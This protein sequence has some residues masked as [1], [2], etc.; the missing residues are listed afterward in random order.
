MNTYAAKAERRKLLKTSALVLALSVI[1][2]AAW[3]VACGGGPGRTNTLPAAAAAA[4][5]A[6]GSL[7]FGN[8]TINTTSAAQTVTL[9][10][11]GNA[12]LSIAGISVTGT[13]AGDFVQ[14]NACGSSL[15]AGA[16]C[17]IGVTF[18]P[19]ATGTRAGTLTITDNSGTAGSTQTV[20]L[21]GTGTSVPA[22][23][24]S[25]SPLSLAF[26]NETVYTT[27]TAQ[28]LTLSN[29]GNT[30][31]SITSLALTGSNA[32]DFDQSNT[33]GSSLAAGANCTIAVMFTPSVTGTRAASVGITDNASD[34]P[35]TVSLSGTGTA[36]VASL[37]PTSLTFAS[38]AVGATSAAQTIT[39]NNTGNSAL[40]ISSLAL[41]GTNPN[42]FAQTNNCGAGVAAGANCTINVTFTPAASGTRSAAVTLTDNATG[43]PQTVS[44]SGT[45]TAAVA[46]L[47]PSS[48][49]FAS[50]AVGATSAAQTITL[51][52]TGNSAL[53]ISSLALTGTNP[54]D[55]AQTNN[56]GAGVTAGANCTI[57]V[58]F[59]P[60]ASGT[61]S[62][63]VTLTDNA[64]GS[65]QSVSLT[66]TGTAAVASL[67]P[68]S[69]TFASQ[70]VGATSAA[71]TITLNN[72][73]NSALSISSLA[74][75]GTNPNDFAQSNNCG[76]SVAAGANCTIS[77]RF[78]P[79]ASG[80]RTASLS[81]TDNASGSPQ[82]VS[83]S[84]TG[85]LALASLSP[86]SLAFGNQS[87][88]TTST[89]Q[90]LTLSNTGNAPLSITSLAFT[91]TNASDFDQSNTCGSSLAA[92]ANCTI[93]VMFTPSV[94]GTRAASLSVSDNASGS[95]QS[96]PLSG[97]G[98]HDVILSWTPSTT[99][100]AVV[101]YNVYR[102]TTL[103]GP[104][105][106]QLNSTPI[107]GTTYSD[108][109]VQAGQ[110]YYYVVTAVASDDVTQSAY[111][112]QTS[113]TVPS[114]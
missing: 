27:S 63:A 81:I 79:S 2:A 90:T 101:G 78:T 9:T 51:N 114:P 26:G 32:S 19:P 10:N 112:N 67:S 18:T 41:T 84:G 92:G 20:S 100:P 33:C 77:V 14:T 34:S 97:A 16:S 94:T 47:S 36:A 46:S 23:A 80:S 37:S 95:P 57:N 87:V 65:P 76:A 59:T 75:M 44:L 31:L 8:Q 45:G 50:Q 86:T 58:T 15:A 109:T 98:T 42:D 104:Y 11:S 3:Q 21:G 71:Q 72:T 6:P 105:P 113:A 30:A 25:L 35:Q 52:N 110:T 40:S 99:P 102:G 73:G 88:G 85:A 39:L 38:Q 5:I 69:L 13:N 17:M 74:L 66:G 12:A 82:T 28:T 43:S 89:A 1:L 56:C 103:G 53:S 93:V 7:A 68:S 108:E 83:L 60:A 64:T 107:N 29:T 54:N 55:F 22:P 24:V 49:T 111:S 96:V 106:T 48:L 62:A 91:G 70:A 61:R 4:S